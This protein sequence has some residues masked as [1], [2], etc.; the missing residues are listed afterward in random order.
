VYKRKPTEI[1]TFVAEQQGWPLAQP[2]QRSGLPEELRV[3]VPPQSG[4]V[5]DPILLLYGD[6]GTATLRKALGE[7]RN[8]ILTVPLRG[9]RFTGEVRATDCDADASAAGQ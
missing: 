3:E 9:Y 8:V 4:L 1:A 6:D 2:E 5:S 7:D